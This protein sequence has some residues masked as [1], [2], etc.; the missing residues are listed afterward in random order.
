MHVRGELLNGSF[1]LEFD[2][3]R[4][5]RSQLPVVLY[6]YWW[7]GR[8]SIIDGGVDI[9]GYYVVLT[10]F[11]YSHSWSGQRDHIVHQTD[12]TN[13]SV[14]KLLKSGCTRQE[15]KRKEIQKTL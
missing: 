9:K 14:T 6:V 7:I 5:Q 8:Q 1:G 13:L 3:V 4:L 10:R 15:E 2:K 12:S 11:K